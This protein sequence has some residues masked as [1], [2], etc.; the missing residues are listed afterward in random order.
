MEAL[1]KTQDEFKIDSTRIYL[2]GL[3]MGGYGTWFLAYHNSD[4]FA[5]LVSVC[6]VIG[7]YPRYP[8]IG[9]TDEQESLAGLAQRVKHIPTWI[10]HGAKDNVFPAQSS[11]NIEAAFQETGADVHYTEFP[12]AGHN[13]WDEAYAFRPMIDW[14]FLQKKK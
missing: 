6:S 10:F 12:D 3:S 7:G 9:G 14:L 4:V 11:R 2:T 5:A 13:S 8:W 1:R